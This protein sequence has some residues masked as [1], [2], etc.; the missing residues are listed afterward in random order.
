[1]CGFAGILRPPG[2][3]RDELAEHAGRMSDALAHRGPDDSGLWIDERAGIALG[4]RRLAILDLSPHGH[5][6]MSSAS[7][8]FV[9]AFNGEVYNFRELR[10]ELEAHGHRFRGHSDTEVV[11]AAF[12]QWGIDDAVPRFVGMFGM[13]V[14]DTHRRELTLFR[15]R[16]GKKPL[17]VYHRAGD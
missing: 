6:P 12:E 4:F 17:Y 9:V 16:L 7:G 3:T 1:M 11:L 8:R 14:W 2:C 15:D 10:R 5:Q 13:A